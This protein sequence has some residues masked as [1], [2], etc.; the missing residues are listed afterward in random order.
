MRSSSLSALQQIWNISLCSMN[1]Q[2]IMEQCTNFGWDLPSQSTP[3]HWYPTYS[4]R[5]WRGVEGARWEK[6]A[7]GIDQRGSGTSSAV[8]IATRCNKPWQNWRDSLH[9]PHKKNRVEFSVQET[10]LSRKC[11]IWRYQNGAT[12]IEG[13][14][15]WTREAISRTSVD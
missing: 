4:K 9:L 6:S 12:E 2:V 11:C 7:P 15:R 3:L 5:W 10:Q 1:S 8:W 13:A 14:F